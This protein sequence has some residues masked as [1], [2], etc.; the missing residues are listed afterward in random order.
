M[1]C[2]QKKCKYIYEDRLQYLNKYQESG[3][4]CSSISTENVETHGPESQPT[5]V[6]HKN[7]EKMIPGRD[8]LVRREYIGNEENFIGSTAKRTK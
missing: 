5:L 4:S 1:I 3:A 6:E 8:K 2:C 7:E